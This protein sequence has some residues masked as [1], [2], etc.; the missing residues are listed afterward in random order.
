M[1]SM[2]Q[3]SLSYSLGISST[4][5]N[6]VQHENVNQGEQS[7]YICSITLPYFYTAIQRWM[8]L[9][10]NCEQRSAMLASRSRRTYGHIQQ[11]R[12]NEQCPPT[13]LQV[14]DTSSFKLD[15][16]TFTISCLKFFTLFQLHLYHL[17]LRCSRCPEL[18]HPPQRHTAEAAAVPRA[19]HSHPAAAELLGR[20]C[21]KPQPHKQQGQSPFKGDLGWKEVHLSLSDG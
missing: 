19:H 17:H 4:T 12:G 9:H 13:T 11:G 5:F 15:L 14:T 7:R 18:Q 10:C 8:Q 16:S 1:M 6:A 21:V 3:V 20:H 2:F